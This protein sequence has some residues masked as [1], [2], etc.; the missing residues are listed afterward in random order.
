MGDAELMFDVCV[1]GSANLDLVATV[2]RLP[3]PGET[4]PGGSFAEYPGG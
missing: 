4:V 3:G 1:V 2:D